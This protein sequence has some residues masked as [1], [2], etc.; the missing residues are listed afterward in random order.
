MAAKFAISRH[1]VEVHS[2]QVTSVDEI[3]DMQRIATMSTCV[4][5]SAILERLAASVVSEIAKPSSQLR[6]SLVKA[7]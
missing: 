3:L 6:A 4:G 5:A 1:T 2:V 7:P